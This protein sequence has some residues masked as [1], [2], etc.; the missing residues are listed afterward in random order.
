M[1]KE[2]PTELELYR[3]LYYDV[4]SSKVFVY[5]CWAFTAMM[6]LLI[7]GVYVL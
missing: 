1:S 7:I 6:A 3:D 4:T 2:S 5:G